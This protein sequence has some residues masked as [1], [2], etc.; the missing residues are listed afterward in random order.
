MGKASQSPK[1]GFDLLKHEE[2][3]QISLGLKWVKMI[4]EIYPKPV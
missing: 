4:W 2:F 3:T 1:T